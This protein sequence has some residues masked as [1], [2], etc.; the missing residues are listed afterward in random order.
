L[1]CPHCGAPLEPGARF[2]HSCGARVD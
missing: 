1:Y 2:C